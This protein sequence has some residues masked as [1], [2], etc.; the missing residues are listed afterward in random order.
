MLDMNIWRPYL[1]EDRDYNGKPTHLP[2]LSGPE[3]TSFVHQVQELIQVCRNDNRTM[4]DLLTAYEIETAEVVSVTIGKK[5][6]RTQRYAWEQEFPEDIRA[7]LKAQTSGLSPRGAGGSGG[8]TTSAPS[9]PRDGS[10]SVPA[11]PRGKGKDHGGS[12]KRAEGGGR[13]KA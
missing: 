6:K 11:S 9:T 13:K 1:E 8:P 3:S 2:S 10:G 4:K 7:A 12:R 5:Q